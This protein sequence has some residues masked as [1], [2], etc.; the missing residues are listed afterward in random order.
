VKAHLTKLVWSRKRANALL[1][2][3]IFVSFIVLFGLFSAGL[4]YV[5]RISRPLGFTHD[6]LYTVTVEADEFM[7]SALVAQYGGLVQRIVDRLRTMPEAVAV[8]GMSLAPFELATTISE[9]EYEGR[10]V[11]GEV[12]AMM[13]EANLALHIE[14]IRGR[15]FSAW[16]DTLDWTPVVVNRTMARELFR[17]QDPLGR[18]VREDP[19][20]QVI[21]VVDEFR[22]GGKL[23]P[24]APSIIRRISLRKRGETI[25]RHF[26]V[27]VQPGTTAE[28]EEKA[29]GVMRST[30]PGWPFRI[31]PTDNVRERN[32]KISIAPFAV[33]VLIG[34]FLMIMVVLGMIGVFW[35]SVT[36][37]THEIGL[38]RAFGGS[39]SG[40]YRQLISEILI[41]A[42]VGT[43]GATALILQ[44]P[45]LGL[46][47]GVD[48]KT[49]TG[50]LALSMVV[51][52]ALAT[53]SGLYP[54]WLAARIQPAHALHYE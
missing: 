1:I 9:L 39:R 45:L 13:D 27:R 10:R 11:E 20:W 41:L 4:P 26:V 14:V 31:D 47:S 23:A 38:R 16:D 3:E 21:G 17:D 29:L 28:F 19:R 33:A 49:F 25:P 7:E 37:R 36:R 8:A 53:V 6:N 43:V 44:L 50:A 12:V 35:L 15:W 34:G 2:L 18:I 32:L 30:A 40:I 52:Y 46:L 48:W 54:A 42:S 5:R 24:L 22:R 51:T